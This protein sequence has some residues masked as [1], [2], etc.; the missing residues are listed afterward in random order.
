MND[1]HLMRPSGLSAVGELPW[2]AHFCQ[3]YGGAADLVDALVPYFKAGLENNEKCLWVTCD[4]LRADDA[5]VALRNAVPDLAARMAA[6][7]IEI[8][9][10]EQWYLRTGHQDA[11]ATL[12]G[13]VEREQQALADGFSGIRLTGN[14]YW[15]ERNDW[16][17]F[18]DYE[19]RVTETFRGH[20]IIGLCSY[21][22]QRCQPAD[23]LDVVANHQFA[24]VRREGEWQV[25]ETAA[26][27]RAKQDLERVNQELERRVADRTAELERAVRA[28]DE[29]L[30][31]AS[32]ELKTP[33]TSLQLYVQ[34]M[35]RSNG[36][37]L[38]PEQQS[39]MDRVLRQCTRLEKLVNN[40]L[41][42][43]RADA[44]VPPLHV[45]E[46]DLSALTQDLAERF[47][48]EFAR[49]RCQ[50]RLDAPLPV[51]GRW[52]AMRVEQALTN[53]FQNATRY[54][55][56]SNVEISV[57]ADAG[58]AKVV[59]SDSGPGVPE[60]DQER[61]FGRF[62]QSQS[63]RAFAGGFGLGLWIVRQVA[64]AHGGSISL[65]SQPGHGATFTLTLPLGLT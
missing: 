11:T 2:G 7:Q 65:T 21:C 60:E 15:V 17:G 20:R 22:L 6:N 51:V 62:T 34:G 18:V 40:L 37:A 46:G 10:H 33:I 44:I 41:D 9:D 56:G 12:R 58:E 3:F 42:V 32:H 54:A 57:T 27:S 38:Q 1:L 63:P 31:V 64:E 61:I 25:L 52:D 50:V 29:F 59:V 39:R 8:L 26:L 53:L 45:E 55:P 13:W 14:T 48:E 28:R 23:I 30:S 43:S 49:A 24:L 19:S 5:K 35:L 47:A 36:G 4:P 16:T